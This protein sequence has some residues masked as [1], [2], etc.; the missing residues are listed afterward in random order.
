MVNEQCVV[1]IKSSGKNSKFFCETHQ[2]ECVEI[3][4]PSEGK[5]AQRVATCPISG[6]VAGYTG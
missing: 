4:S 5:L 3:S 6:Q 2:L 1:V